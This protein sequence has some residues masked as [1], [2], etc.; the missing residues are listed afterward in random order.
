MN[1][2]PEKYLARKRARYH[3]VDKHDPEYM[4]TARERSRR[5]YQLKTAEERKEI[6][7]RYR[8]PLSAE[9]RERKNALKREAY[10]KLRGERPAREIV[11]ESIFKHKNTK[12]IPTAV[13]DAWK[14]SKPNSILQIKYPTYEALKRGAARGDFDR[15]AA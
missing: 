9:A 14:V 8:S 1:K 6:N 2:T 4:R 3:A 12:P 15:M 5:N 13:R 10:A 11:R 7:A